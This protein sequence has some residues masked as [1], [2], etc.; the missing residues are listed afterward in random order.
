MRNQYF[1]RIILAFLL[2]I[3]LI[4]AIVAIFSYLAKPN[5]PPLGLDYFFYFLFTIG[6]GGLIRGVI[7]LYVLGGWANTP[8]KFSAYTEVVNR[9]SHS[10]ILLGGTVFILWLT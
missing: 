7:E 10:L 4:A 5:L 8:R 6:I 1:S 9:T 2:G 3:G